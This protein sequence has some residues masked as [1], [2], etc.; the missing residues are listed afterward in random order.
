MTRFSAKHVTFRTANAFIAE[1][2]R[3]HRPPQGGIVCLGLWQGDTLVGVGVLGRPVARMADDGVTAEITRLCVL[4]EARHAAS[5]LIGRLR[6]VAQSLGYERVISYTL[7]SEGGASLRATG[8][9]HRGAAGGG[10]WSRPSRPRAA[11]TVPETKARWDWRQAPAPLRVPDP[12]A[13][14]G[15]TAEAALREGF[16]AVLIEREAE[17]VADINRRLA[18]MRGDDTPLFAGAAS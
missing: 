1:H 7:P 18:R 12:I 6:R 8:A 2:H 13:G 15:T 3:H 4:P 10:E 14:S 5:A 9:E 16:A 17:Y 11:A